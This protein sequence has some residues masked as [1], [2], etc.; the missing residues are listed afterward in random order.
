[1]NRFEALFSMEFRTVLIGFDWLWEFF[2]QFFFS[3]YI[4]VLKLCFLKRMKLS[5]E[6]Y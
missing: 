4:F 5:Y 1:M 3:D 2:D 6:L